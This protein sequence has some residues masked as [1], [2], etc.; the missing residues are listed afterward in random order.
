MR[1]KYPFSCYVERTGATGNCHTA[2][3][4]SLL[5]PGKMLHFNALNEKRRFRDKGNKA[6]AKPAW[7]ELE[8]SGLGTFLEEK[9]ARGTRVISISHTFHKILI[10]FSSYTVF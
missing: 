9:V 2:T 3:T 1:M 5:L 7:Q 8:R 6:G 4:F 10:L